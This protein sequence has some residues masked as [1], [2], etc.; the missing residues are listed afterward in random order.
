M[1]IWYLLFGLLSKTVDLKLI[2]Q[3]YVDLVFIIQP[4]EQGSRFEANYA[5][6]CGFGIYYSAL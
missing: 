4:S 2:M 1:W 6:L 5:I 3:S